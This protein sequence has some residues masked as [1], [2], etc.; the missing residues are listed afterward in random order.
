MPEFYDRAPH[1]NT[2]N[3]WDRRSNEAQNGTLGHLPKLTFWTIK[4]GF[5]GPLIAFL[6]IWSTSLKLPRIAIGTVLE[7]SK[8]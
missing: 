8:H 6:A 4:L 5:E 2:A 7:I 1:K 3:K